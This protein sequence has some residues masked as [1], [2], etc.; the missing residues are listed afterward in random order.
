ML[1]R[2]MDSNRGWKIY[3]YTEKHKCPQKCV[4]RMINIFY[5]KN[6]VWTNVTLWTI[7]GWK[8]S[9]GL[10]RWWDWACLKENI[11][12]DDYL[13]KSTCVLKSFQKGNI[14]HKIVCQ[15]R[16]VDQ[17]TYVA[18][19]SSISTEIYIYLYISVSIRLQVPINPL[20]REHSP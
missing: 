18:T 14:Y 4:N 6:L 20:V 9:S 16:A 17:G 2:T 5:L 7:F 13:N 3:N 1:S 12:H 15:Q 11:I 8:P 10:V 19:W